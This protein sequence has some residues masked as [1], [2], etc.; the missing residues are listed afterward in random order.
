LISVQQI[1]QPQQA[2]LARQRDPP[3]VAETL[4][5]DLIVHVGVLRDVQRREMEAEGA[6]AAQEATH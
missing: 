2:L 3:R 5:N 1:P 6:H 4:R